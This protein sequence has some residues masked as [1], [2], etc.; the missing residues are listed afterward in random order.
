M[1]EERAKVSETRNIG[2]NVT[3]GTTTS[4]TAPQQM[5][6]SQA[7]DNL[8][9]QNATD[10]EDGI[11]S[12]ADTEQ[13]NTVPAYKMDKD[14]ENKISRIS[15]FNRRTSFLWKGTEDERTP[16]EVVEQVQ[17]INVS[18]ERADKDHEDHRLSDAEDAAIFHAR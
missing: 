2:A 5:A 9:T 18:A 4:A 15:H 12:R 16:R 1:L 3:T 11:V 10:S 7:E 14:W 17:K 13:K 6:Q 8:T